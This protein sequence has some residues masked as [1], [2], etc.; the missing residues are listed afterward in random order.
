[1]EDRAETSRGGPGMPTQAPETQE[2]CSMLARASEE[3]GETFHP[4][5]NLGWQVFEHRS[6]TTI[7][8][9][10]KK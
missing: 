6:K 7:G 1:M 10:K 2:P 3:D 8:K 9:T 5:D 4:K